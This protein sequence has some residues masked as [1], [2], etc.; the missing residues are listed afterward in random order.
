MTKP[1]RAQYGTAGGHRWAKVKAL[2]AKGCFPL[3]I[4]NK[5]KVDLALIEQ[6]IEDMEE[7]AADEIKPK[8]AY[9]FADKAGANQ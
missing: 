8:W 9:P 4:A 6:D 2:R 1:P 3:E 5:L 7:I